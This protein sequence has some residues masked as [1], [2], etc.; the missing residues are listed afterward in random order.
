MEKVD[1]S[2]EL[3]D[4]AINTLLDFFKNIKNSGITPHFDSFDLSLLVKEDDVNFVTSLL[5]LRND[6]DIKNDILSSACFHGFFNI[7]EFII[8]K[9]ADVNHSNGDP[10]YNACFS[11][12]IDII[13]LL[14]NSGANITNEA[15]KKAIQK[16]K[17][18]TVKLLVEKGAKITNRELKLAI[19][20]NNYQIFKLLFDSCGCD[21]CNLYDYFCFAIK[22]GNIEIVKLLLKRGIDIK[23]KL[24]FILYDACLK[25]DPEII[26]LLIEEGADFTV[27]DNYPLTWA[28]RNN[29]IDIVELLIQKGVDVTVNDNKAIISACYGN[30]IEIAKLLLKAGA[31]P[32]AQKCKAFFNVLLYTSTNIEML[33]ILK[34]ACTKDITYYYNLA[35]L[36]AI[37]DN[38]TRLVE[39]L[40]NSGANVTTNNNACIMR[41]I[42]KKVNI[43]IIRLI[44]KAGA[45]ININN[46][47][48]LRSAVLQNRLDVVKELINAGAD[49]TANDNEALITAC[50]N[51]NYEIAKLLLES[52]ANPNYEALFYVLSDK[53]IL[54]LFKDNLEQIMASSNN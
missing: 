12:K 42:D 13:E 46:S 10:I 31:D 6:Q 2:F 29:Q 52:G 47:Y 19:E 30:N 50:K 27:K 4:G 21:N 24:P 38:D 7:A 40:I 35:I 8:Q 15:L 26:K 36:D 37:G 54:T 23:N 11:V 20:Y 28:I 51:K 44:I 32:T 33:S 41:A 14:L 1:V 3:E 17:F 9:G 5:D 45:E 18:E 49:V 22:K 53:K 48:P 39:Y 34:E 43:D 16:G 25:G